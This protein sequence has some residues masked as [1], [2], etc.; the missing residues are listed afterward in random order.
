VVQGSVHR[1]RV[2]AKGYLTVQGALAGPARV[3]AGGYLLVQGAVAG[4]V[5]DRGGRVG[6]TASVGPGATA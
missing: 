3:E 5:T 2:L 4:D 6:A 1:A